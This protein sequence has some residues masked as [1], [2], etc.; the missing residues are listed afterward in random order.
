MKYNYNY[1]KYQIEIVSKMKE[2]TLLQDDYV[3]IYVIQG[4][5][6]TTVEEKEFR[7]TEGD[8]YLNNRNVRALLKLGENCIY[9]KIKFALNVLQ[10]YYPQEQI[11]F[12]CNS[13]LHKQNGNEEIVCLL[14]EMLDGTISLPKGNDNIKM[15]ILFYQLLEELFQYCMVEQPVIFAITKFEEQKKKVMEYVEENYR[16]SLSLKE[17]AEHSYITYYYLSRN[18]R[19]MFGMNFY[20]YLNQVRLK[21]V[22]S[23]LLYTNKSITQIAIDNGYGSAS[24]FNRIF[25]QHFQMTPI[26]YKKSMERREKEQLEIELRNRYITT[27]R[28][29]KKE[30]L[31]DEII[32]QADAQNQAAY[33]R[34]FTKMINGGY[35]PDLVDAD[36]QKHIAI[37][38]DKIGFEYV[39]LYN[40]FCEQMEIRN[41]H[42]VESLNFSKLDRILDFCVT[43]QVKPWIDFGDKPKNI[44]NQVSMKSISVQSEIGKP[45][46]RKKNEF[47]AVLNGFMKHI[48]RRYGKRQTSGWIFEF[49]NDYYRPERQN[50]GEKVSFFEAFDIGYDIVKKW[51]PTAEVGGSGMMLQRLEE[52]FLEEWTKHRSPDFVSCIYFPYSE[53][54]SGKKEN[55]DSMEYEA[56]IHIFHETLK[57]VREK[58]NK[59][60]LKCPLYISEF[61]SNVSNRNYQ[62][63]SCYQ[64][65]YCM[66]NATEAGT[67]PDIVG[68]WS[69]SDNLFLAQDVKNI[70]YGG[71][72][73]LT[74]DGVRKPVFYCLEFLG[75]LDEKMIFSNEECMITTDGYDGYTIVSHNYQNLPHQ[76]YMQSGVQWNIERHIMKEGKSKRLNLK[77]SNMEKGRYRGVISRLGPSNGGVLELWSSLGYDN[78]LTEDELEYLN[79]AAAPKVEAIQME[80]KGEELKLQIDIEPH[81]IVMVK[82]YKCSNWEKN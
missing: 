54:P 37:L 5:V 4:E 48:T 19:E 21:H 43:H 16:E 49:W 28:M 18:F 56:E 38:A 13:A 33:G 45:V 8:V 70:M 63:D 3:L 22:T 32:V 73:V 20:D 29:K 76:Y 51:L 65:A 6:M 31:I 46:F 30:N 52:E 14:K 79:R 57:A 1:G 59:Y 74:R 80:S 9:A 58:M 53:N 50:G 12:L 66:I 75:K 40:P 10:R 25:R 15:T 64:A 17:V 24:A 42:D 82:M 11:L 62:N 39:R 7:L 67:L 78:D 26:E 27:P 2:E 34:P 44:V 23:D 55:E 47:V 60:G 36:I 77:I 68:Y 35:M 72:G 61:S 41:G 81:E 69:S 71:S